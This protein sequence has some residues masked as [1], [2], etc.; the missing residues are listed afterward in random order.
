MLAVAI[1]TWY[2][3]G[4]AEQEKQRKYLNLAIGGQDQL[5][6]KSDWN[7]FKNPKGSTTIVGLLKDVSFYDQNQSVPLHLYID[8]AYEQQKKFN[9]THSLVN[10]R[11]R[12][13]FMIKDLYKV[14]P[15]VKKQ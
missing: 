2:Y 1:K 8:F 6:M 7:N 9:A 14:Y 4:F 15:E 3:L 11:H 10:N 13:P 12:P 5:W